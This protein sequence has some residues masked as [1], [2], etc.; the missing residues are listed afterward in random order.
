M[1]EF[2]RP[3]KGKST[4]KANANINNPRK[5]YVSRTAKE[6]GCTINAVILSAPCNL[7]VSFL[8]GF[9]WQPLE[10]GK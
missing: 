7:S 1:M 10:D 5:P 4:A 2:E 6:A 9:S 8:R 3:A